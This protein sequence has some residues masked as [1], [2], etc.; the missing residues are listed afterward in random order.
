MYLQKAA[1]WSGMGVC[2]LQ[3]TAQISEVSG[4]FGFT[5][6]SV[7]L[8]FLATHL[9]KFELSVSSLCRLQTHTHTHART[10]RKKANADHKC[11]HVVLLQASTVLGEFD[12]IHGTRNGAGTAERVCG[13]E[14]VAAP[15]PPLWKGRANHWESLP[16]QER[17]EWLPCREP[18]GAPSWVCA[19]V[20]LCCL[21]VCTSMPTSV[22][23][24]QW[25][26]GVRLPEI[27]YTETRLNGLP[28]CRA[29]D[30]LTSSREAM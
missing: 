11:K 24:C 25:L 23:K 3:R 7:D 26:C 28:G 16:S 10:V 12:S 9:N 1:I 18:K 29:P 8:V 17:V 19:W 4:I 22:C 14:L 13:I 20:C 27:V 2:F 30:P 5:L 6:H 21:F 15:L